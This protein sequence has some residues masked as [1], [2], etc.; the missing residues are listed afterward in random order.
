VFSFRILPLLIF[1]CILGIVNKITEIT[2]SNPQLPNFKNL[3]FIKANASEEINN[4]YLMAANSPASPAPT[5][6][7]SSS[8]SGSSSSSH[9]STTNLTP[10]TS[11]SLSEG[12]FCL[13][14]H[15]SEA[16]LDVLKNL[17]ERN[18]KLSEWD[19]ELKH[20]QEIIVATENSIQEKLKKLER[21][22]DEVKGLLNE[23]NSQEN[24]KIANLVKIYE[25]MKPADAAKIFDHLDMKVLLQVFNK[26][27]GTSAAPILAY[28]DP[29]KAREI[30]INIASGKDLGAPQN[31]ICP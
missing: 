13:T 11:N 18:K 28:M 10:N 14:Q 24:Q 9:S 15:F 25:T 4:S 26:M 23:Y 12:N 27:R 2:G 6:N 29:I 1:F 21:L 20:R 30:T 5:K 17:S 16:E 7:H 8:S 22:K 3:L 19:Q 31:L